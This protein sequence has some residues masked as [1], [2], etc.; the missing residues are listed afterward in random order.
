MQRARCDICREEVRPGSPWVHADCYGTIPTLNDLIT[1]FVHAFPDEAFCA[2][3]LARSIGVAESSVAGI[4]VA[5]EGRSI[6]GR[7]GTCARCNTAEHVVA[8]RPC[9]SS[10]PPGRTSRSRA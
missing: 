10:R 6:A 1:A 8:A 3:C 7:N 9:R 4:I 2:E 5:L